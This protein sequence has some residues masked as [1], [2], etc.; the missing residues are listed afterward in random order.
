M[1]KAFVIAPQPIFRRGLITTLENDPDLQVI[2]EANT[3]TEAVQAAKEIDPDILI[4]DTDGELEDVDIKE[5]VEL[6]KE[7]PKAKMVLLSSR[8]NNINEVLKAGVQG[9]LLKSA[10]FTELIDS[11]RLIAG[12]NNVV[13]TTKVNG[14][15]IDLFGGDI[16]NGNGGIRLSPREREVLGH[17]ARGESTK[18]IADACYISQTTVKAH[19]AKIIDKL[20]ARNRSE[21]V[22]LAIETGILERDR[23]SRVQ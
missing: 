21:A 3:T 2:A 12:G 20:S 13:Y 10:D 16:R 7:Y 11:V 14:K 8:G 15:P 5:I 6:Q 18:E 9:Y 17:I 1:I 4:L 22:A 23:I 19:V